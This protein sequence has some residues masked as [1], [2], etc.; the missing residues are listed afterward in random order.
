MKNSSTSK[1][2]TR[3][4]SLTV[5]VMAFMLGAGNAHALTSADPYTATTFASIPPTNVEPATTTE[6]LVMLVMGNDH[7]LFY[8]GYNDWTD[9]DGDGLID[10]TYK[11]SIDYYGYYDSYKCYTYDSSASPR[12]FSP[13]SI[14]TDKYCNTASGTTEEW[15]G[16]FLNWATM[17]RMDIVR[18]VLYGGKRVV[19]TAS[20]TI[21]ERAFIPLDAHSFAKFYGGGDL[22]HLT[23]FSYAEGVTLCNT[24]YHG[25]SNESQD[26]TNPPL[27]RVARGDFRYWNAN[28]RWQCTWD[29]EHGSQI[30]SDTVNKPATAGIE[31]PIRATDGATYSSM[32]PDF[33]ARVEACASSALIGRENCKTYGSNI[34]PVGLLHT[35]GENDQIKFGLLTGSYRYNKSGG[36]VRKDISSFTDEVDSASGIFTGADGIVTTLDRFRITRYQYQ[37]GYYNGTDNCKWGKT[38]F[39]DGDCSNWGNP[40]TEMYL[41]AVRYLAGLTNNPGFSDGK[42]DDDPYISGLTNVGSWTDPYNSNNTCAACN[43]II[44]NTSEFTYDADSLDM[45]GLP[46]SPDA[47][48]ITNFIGSAGQEDISGNDWF[49]GE[50]ATKTNQMCTAKEITNFG[51]VKGLCPTAPRLEGTY[52][53]SGIA[54]WAHNYD[55]R[56][57]LVGEQKPRTYAVALSP[58][59]PKIE[60][61]VPASDKTVTIL[62]A[63]RNTSL[64]PNANC[65]IVNFSVVEANKETSP[66]IFEGVFAVHWEDSEQGG[67]YDQD[68]KGYISYEINSSEIKIKTDVDRESGIYAMGFGFIISG[69][70]QDGFHVYSGVNGF[71]YTDPVPSIPGCSNCDVADAEQSH[72]FTLGDSSAKLLEDPLWYVAKWGGF[73]DLNGNTLPDLEAEWDSVINDTGLPG[74]DGVPDN[75]FLA[76]NPATLERQLGKVFTT[77]TER[78]STGTSAAVVANSIGG[79]GVVYQALYQPIMTDKLDP[80]RKINWIGLLHGIFIDR[81]SQLREDTNQNGKLDDTATDY[82][83]EFFYDVSNNRTQAFRFSSPDEGLTR[84]SVGAVDLQDLAS[85]WNASDQLGKLTN[86]TAQRT[87]SDVITPATGRHIFTW[88]DANNDG[89]VDTGETADFVDSTFTA[90]NFG[91]LN[92]RSDTDGD[93]DIDAIDAQNIVNFVRGEENI[94]GTSFRSRTLDSDG[95]GTDEIYRLGDIIHSSPAVLGVP[96]DDYD[97]LYGDTSYR[98]FRAQYLNRRQVVFV[99]ANDG[100]LHA[101]NGGFYDPTNK[102]YKTALSTEAAHPLGAELWAYVPK[103]LL[104]HLQWLTNINYPHVYYVDGDP[105]LFDVNIF[106]NDTTH[107]NGWGTI[108]V[109]TM[110]L[111][112][113]AQ[114]AGSTDTGV[115]VDVDGDATPEYTARS[116]IMIFDVTDPE[117]PPTLLAEYSDAQLGFTTSTPEILVQR[118]PAADGTWTSPT[119]NNWYLVFGSGPTDLP[120]VTSTQNAYLFA[121]SLNDLMSGMLTIDTI[122]TGI[123]KSY[124]GQA[125]SVDWNYNYLSDAIYFGTVGLKGM[126]TDAETPATLTKPIKTDGRLLR[127]ITSTKSGSGATVSETPSAPADWDLSTVINPGQA[128]S[129]LPITTTDSYGKN[130]IFAGTGR[131]M[132]ITDNKSNNRESFYGIKETMD[133]DIGIA[134]TPATSPSYSRNTTS[135]QD[136]AKLTNVTGVQ[137]FGDGVMLDPGS[138]LNTS[139]KDS[140]GNLQF[141]RLEYFIQGTAGWYRDFAKDTHSDGSAIYTRN[142]TDPSMYRSIVLFSSYRPPLAS[143]TVEGN[144]FFSAVYAGT[145]TAYPGAGL[146]NSTTVFNKGI[147][148]TEDTLDME[149]GIT[150]SPKVYKGC[151]TCDAGAII[152]SGVGTLKSKKIKGSYLNKGRQSWREIIAE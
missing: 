149:T 15:S 113:G 38:S 16:N 1:T 30:N 89:F 108:L 54:Y 120:T 55:I 47:V 66:G 131:L 106:A 118:Q 81:F 127:L 80:T 28:E 8:K 41:E 53:M 130:W 77:I 2:R 34:K 122:D 133:S 124:I 62:P 82:I 152:G 70:T 147:A 33:E 128:F 102:A 44:L 68:M 59:M 104:P 21:L 112:G 27:I 103:N 22:H 12:H 75:Y 134:V 56:T 13:S 45:S 96:S 43:I 14:T 79:T 145:G 20:S 83:I 50:T 90:T 25:G 139:I 92:V 117:A 126:T 141:S 32:G 125:H 148:L 136:A 46:G 88:L 111:G 26:V 58:A 37:Y 121:M 146:G 65:A 63:C 18:K 23:P 36:V 78:F 72:E 135:G 144:G 116:A 114:V 6:P 3:F 39:V 138:V 10:S 7:Q 5:F 150:S 42:N 9:L 151:P 73:S 40:I 61:P 100:M 129:S 11:N 85:L 99:G 51:D 71:D 132:N 110:R 123:V 119:V 76:H 98:T 140:D 84:T 64:T 69:T 48:A 17:T 137:V 91:Y 115:E 105:R 29:D 67:D 31:D 4:S 101:F 35:Y 142:F 109:A 87:Y 86:L 94:S 19:D 143:C 49:V 60:I 93:S 97:G 24:T 57:A 95:D 74:S 52:S 107:P